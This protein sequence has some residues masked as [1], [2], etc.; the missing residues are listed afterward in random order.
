MEARSQLPELSHGTPA[1]AHARTGVAC[2][3]PS[4]GSAKIDAPAS[5][6][7][8]RGGGYIPRFALL[9]GHPSRR[10]RERRHPGR[11]ID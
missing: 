8:E 11:E 4:N 3:A 1:A 2:T 5:R 7:A 6:I 9:N 10:W